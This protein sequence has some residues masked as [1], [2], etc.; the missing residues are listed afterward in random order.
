MEKILKPDS[1]GAEHFAVTSYYTH[2]YTNMCA[3][4]S[5]SH[6]HGPSTMQTPGSNY[7]LKNFGTYSR[8]LSK[9]KIR[10]G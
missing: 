10:I 9:R 3:T 2:M 5:P 1:E 8:L 7:T 6:S 4:H